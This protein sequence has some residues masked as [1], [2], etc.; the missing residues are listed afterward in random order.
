MLTINLVKVTKHFALLDYIFS[1]NIAKVLSIIIRVRKGKNYLFFQ[2]IYS[3]TIISL[4]HFAS[5]V[6]QTVIKLNTMQEKSK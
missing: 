4:L 2:P 6:I 5:A 3:C 1:Q